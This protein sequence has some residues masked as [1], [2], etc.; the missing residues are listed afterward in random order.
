M[1][2]PASPR[3]TLRT[4]LILLAVVTLLP[5]LAFAGV[6]IASSVR[7]QRVAVERGALET[8]RA[9]RTA[10]EREIGSAMAT[11]DV[12]TPRPVFDAGDVRALRAEMQNVFFS[13]PDWANLTLAAPDGRE[14]VNLRSAPGDAPAALIERRSFDE[15]VRTR[16]PTVG[17]VVLEPVIQEHAVAVRAP[18]VRRDRVLYVISA[19]LPARV[20]VEILMSQRLPADWVVA[21]V[22]SQNQHVARSRSQEKFVGKPVHKLL[23]DALGRSSEGWIRSETLEGQDIYASFSRSTKT[24]WSVALG[25]PV[26][27][28]DGTLRRSTIGFV[29]AIGAALLAAFVI[30]ALVS[31]RVADPLATLADAAPRIVR[32]EPV[33]LSRAATSEVQGLATALALAS[34]ERLAAESAL[35]QTS[36]LLQ[37]VF[38]GTSD[39]VFVKDLDGRY[40]MIN[41]AGARLLGRTVADVVGKADSEMFEPE[42]VRHI[43]A[44]DREVTE[45]GESK[46]FEHDA[47][48]AGTGSVRSYLSTKA[49]YRDAEGHIIG[50]V[51]V[52]RDISIRKQVESLRV[53][54]LER[55]QAA[56]TEAEQANRAKD[57]FL[58][59]LSHELRTPL[60][61]VYGWARML[62]QGRLDTGTA[63]RALEVIERNASAQVQLIEDLLDISRVITGKMRLD[64]RPVDLPSVVAGAV[65]SVRPAAEARGIKLGTQLDPAAGPVSGDPERLQQ[66]IWNL[67]SNAVKFTPRGGRVDIDVAPTDGH[68][69]IVVRDTG[70]GI[71]A[72]VLPYVFDRFRQGDSSSTRAHG[73]LGLGLALVRHLT[74]LHGGTVTAASEG[75]G[76]GATFVVRLPISMTQ[77]RADGDATAPPPPSVTSEPARDLDGA[78]VLVVDDDPDGLELI[79]TMLRRANA[80]PRT[81]NSVAA[82]IAVLKSWRPDVVVSDLEMPGEDGYTLLRRVQELE[83][84]LG[85]Q[86]PA[87]AL[88]AYGR[89]ED[90]VRTLSAGFA[91]HIP[92]PVDPVELATVIGALARRQRTSQEAS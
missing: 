30:A 77:K 16:R 48:A 63:A 64:V 34:R 85:I 5:M 37:T 83:R 23:L 46:T 11:L 21:I 87:V 13:Q 90:R 86:L 74:E 92:K 61:A 36:R 71:A 43:A 45:S 22:D 20:F 9:L 44:Q 8:A 28:V 68:V 67:L 25:V 6:F 88:T 82:A 79:V 24:G 17:D 55:E 40:V 81:A 12:V 91:M 76:R 58:A 19:I 75:V 47:T 56:R 70:Q 4:Q 1:A 41:E 84:E 53:R 73:G 15:A 2:S 62:R 72:D 39:A 51:G 7:D 42:S 14:L 3:R 69:E 50:L 80:E 26:E 49:P 29:V 31:R 54:A 89:I 66:I 60:N 59:M 38:E 57:E 33:A 32:G 10:V 78:R 27:A 18:V 35:G 52:S 65:D